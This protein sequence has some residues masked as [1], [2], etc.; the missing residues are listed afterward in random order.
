MVAPSQMMHLIST[1]K[2]PKANDSTQ[3]R[4]KENCCSDNIWD[5]HTSHGKD[6]KRQLRWHLSRPTALLPVLSFYL[7][8]LD[9]ELQGRKLGHERLVTYMKG[10]GDRELKEE[11][12]RGMLLR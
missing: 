2:S 7:S 8:V 1:C 3:Y 9:R 12:P 4:Y 6:D 11:K 5:S 10:I